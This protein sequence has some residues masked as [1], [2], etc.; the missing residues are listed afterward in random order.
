MVLSEERENSCLP[1]RCDVCRWWGASDSRLR[2]RE[3]PEHTYV[4]QVVSKVQ[5][6]TYLLLL[7]CSTTFCIFV[8][9]QHHKLH[10]YLLSTSQRFNMDTLSL[11]L[12]LTFAMLTFAAP[13]ANE[14]TF[15]A[16]SDAWQYRTGGGIVGFIVLVL[17]VIVWSKSSPCLVGE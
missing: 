11:F 4:H 3:Q 16:Q 10:N 6:S 5:N 8:Y 14:P 2:S 15:S 1:R 9:T 12:S 7:L 13:V 17:D